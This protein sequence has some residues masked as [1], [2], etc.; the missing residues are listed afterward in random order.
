M[1]GAREKNRRELESAWTGRVGALGRAIRAGCPR[2]VTLNWDLKAEQE[3]TR[4]HLG[5]TGSGPDQGR[6]SPDTG[7]RPVWPELEKEDRGKVREAGGSLNT[8]QQGPWFKNNN[9]LHSIQGMPGARHRTET[10]ACDTS[11][12]PP[13]T[14]AS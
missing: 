3:P 9:T 8:E 13:Q 5:K 12:H 1:V 6:C 11:F 2:K 7:G 10:S 14:P 4:Q